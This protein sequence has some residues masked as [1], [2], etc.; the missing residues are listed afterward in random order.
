M[1]AGEPGDRSESTAE[2]PASEVGR[3]IAWPHALLACLVCLPGFWWRHL[4]IERAGPP[5][6]Q[7]FD[8]QIFGYDLMKAEAILA[9]L[10]P[11]DVAPL[12]VMT[13]LTLDLAFPVAYCLLFRAL[14]RKL[15]LAWLRRALLAAALAMAGSDIAEN[16][17]TVSLVRYG[18][19]PH[20]VWMASFF[21]LAKWWTLP[22]ILAGLAIG[23][24]HR[25][26]RVTNQ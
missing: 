25:P 10:R 19:Q 20:V 22:L 13:Q 3:G 26:G 11:E 6:V 24:V 18:A 7:I 1:K 23:A 17:C 5:E 2:A 14:A 4:A 12:Y 16:L 9:T 15:Q 21:T 8:T